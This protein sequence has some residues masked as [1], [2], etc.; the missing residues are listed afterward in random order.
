MFRSDRDSGNAR[1]R[2]TR[3]A[4]LMGGL[5]VGALGII[6]AQLYRLQVIDGGRYRPLA[7]RN[8]IATHPLLPMRGRIFDRYGEPLATNRRSL[9]VV[10]VPALANDLKAVV[11]RLGN[12]L[13]LGPA[14]QGHILE[15][16]RKQPG[17]IAIVAAADLT[18]E[19]FARVNLELPHLPGVRPEAVG[20]RRYHHGAILGQVVGHVGAID[21]IALGDEAIV[22]DPR[23]RVGR[24]G[25]ERGL[26]DALRGEGGE[27]RFEVDALGRMVRSLE[28][29]EPVAGKDV[30]L[31]ID[32]GLQARLMRRLASERVA[33]AVVLDIANGDILA[34]ASHPTFDNNQLVE[35]FDPKAWNRLARAPDHPLVNRAL[36]GLYAPGSTFKMVTVLAALEKRVITPRRTLNC[37]GHYSVSGATFD[38]WNHGGHGPVSLHRAI[39]E[40]CDVYH[41]KLARR[42]GIDAIASMARRL[43]FGQVYGTGIAGEKRGIVP[44]AKWKH[45][46]LQKPWYTGETVMAGIGQGYVLATPLQLAV[47]TA[48]LASGKLVVPRII[49]PATEGGGTT[50]RSLDIPE[51]HLEAVRAAMIAVVNEGGGTGHSASF[52]EGGPLVAGKTGTSQV[53]SISSR[54]SNASLPWELR[55]H[56]MFVSYFPANAPRFAVA[57]IVEHGGSGGKAAAPLARDVMAAVLAEGTGRRAAWPSTAAARDAR[58]RTL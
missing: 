16:A 56:A 8:R 43:G 5:Q 31:S 9:Q 20:L 14:V 41:Y 18:Y 57:T 46:Y 37:P 2:F 55:D 45:G 6:G 21:E 48:R 7:E 53:A 4:M 36:R 58:R 47:M 35:D 1:G 42:I 22:R 13:N 50:F 15:R 51:R 10:I 44:D 33:A 12:I 27:E 19:Q 32:T 28:A 49:R 3:R 17:N 11:A 52:G 54:R 26:D 29:R 23:L 24:A 25:V 34:L 38:C 30:H 40:S 39:R